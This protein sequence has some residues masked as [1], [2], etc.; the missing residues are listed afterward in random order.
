MT[1]TTPVHP[2]TSEMRQED[3]DR[4]S[5]QRSRRR[6]ARSIRFAF[7]TGDED[8]LAVTTIVSLGGAFLKAS[9]IPRPGTL[10]NLIERFSPSG[11]PVTV[12]AEVVW[13]S[14]HPTLE[15][16]DTGFG[17]RFIEASTRADPSHLEEFLRILDPTYDGAL[18]TFEERP[19]GA[20]VVYRFGDGDIEAADYAGDDSTTAG[21]DDH[22]GPLTPHH[23]EAAL[24]LPPVP[25]EP[26]S[27][28]SKRSGKTVT[29]IFT[30]LFRRVG[31]RDAEP[32]AEPSRTPVVTS[33]ASPRQV[34]LS[35]G[36]TKLA[37]IVGSVGPHSAR[38]SL[39]GPLPAVG[40]GVLLRPLGMPLA[41]ADLAISAVVA[42]RD[43]STSSVS[44]TFLRTDDP[45]QRAR[46]LDYVELIGRS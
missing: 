45:K 14:S 5:D 20:H 29:G 17:V 6:H 30:S 18:I 12:R 34:A 43:G 10:V 26:S 21:F 1:A 37:G 39:E 24:P 13:T 40:T 27:D 33:P 7:E 2:P 35:W 19:L 16:P 31:R 11:K 38:V 3:S 41:L 36:A 23:V 25:P 9:H 15:R 28:R 4:S 8:H 42:A 22:R 44:L 46:I 32:I